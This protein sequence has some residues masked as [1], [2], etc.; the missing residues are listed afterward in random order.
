MAT[1]T[2]SCSWRSICYF[3]LWLLLIP[4]ARAAKEN[5]DEPI[6]VNARSVETNEKTGVALYRGDVFIEQGQLSIRADRVEIRTHNKKTDV[7]HAT[8]KPAKLRQR[9]DGTAEDLQAEAYRIDYHVAERKLDMAG[10]VKLR[11]GDDRFTGGVL[12]YDLDAKNLAAAGG[13]RTDDRVHAVIQPEK[14]TTQP[15]SG[16]DR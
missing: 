7:I 2:L 16:A 4:L 5:A 8:G 11:R 14:E 10:A 13:E 9:P 1:N 12:H 6:H 15:P 3:S